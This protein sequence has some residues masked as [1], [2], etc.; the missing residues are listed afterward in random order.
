MAALIAGQLVAG[1]GAGVDL[2]Q[3]DGSVMGLIWPDGYSFSSGTAR[4]VMN[5]QG[6]VIAKV[7]D[8]V[9]LGGGES[10]P[11]GPWKVCPDQVLVKVSGAP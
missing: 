6:R 4:S 1:A 5:T 3:A 11:G 10:G 7:G 8:T 2:K 9:E